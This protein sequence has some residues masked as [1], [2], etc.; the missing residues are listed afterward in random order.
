M[1]EWGLILSQ[2]S[3]CHLHFQSNIHIS[4][5]GVHLLLPMQ[6]AVCFLT[7]NVFLDSPIFLSFYDSR[8]LNV[9][10]KPAGLLLKHA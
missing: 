7:Q 2:A 9:C 6:Y 3:C 5:L 1:T 8:Y 10:K 4:Y